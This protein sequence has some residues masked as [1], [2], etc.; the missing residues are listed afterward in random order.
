MAQQDDASFDFAS[1]SLKDLI[2]ARDL[3]HFHLM[4]KANVIGTAVGLYLIRKKEDWPG[5]VGES[6]RPKQK[7]TYART[8]GNSQ[9][10]DYSWP[11]IIVLVREWVDEENFGKDGQPAPWDAVPKRLYLPDGRAVPVCVVMAPPVPLDETTPPVATFRPSAVLGGGLPVEVE[12]QHE[13]HRAT[14][15]CMV[16]DGHTLYALTARHV[17]G[18]SGTEIRAGMRTETPVIGVSSDKQLTRKLFSDVYPA[19]PLRQTWL[20]LDVGLVRIENARDW[21]ANVYG[22]PPIKP[23]FDLYEQNLSLRRLID[24]PVV[25][26]GASSGLLHGRMMALFYRY[27][28]VGGFDYVSDF[29]IAPEEG[30]H[31][32]R[33]GDSGALWQLQMPGP[34]G[35]EDHRPLRQR[36]LRPIAIEWGAQ[37]FVE[38]KAQSTFSVATSLSNICKLLDVELVV[39]HNDG[40]TG[41][42]GAMGHYT[43]G[44]LAI[45]LVQDPELKAFLKANAALL[46]IPLDHLKHAPKNGDLINSGFVPLA[47][48]PDIV[49]K[50]RPPFKDKSGK[51]GGVVGGRDTGSNRGPEH[52]NHHCDADRPWANSQTLPKACIADNSLIN[53]DEWNRYFDAF[54]KPKVA[55][56]HRG[57]LPFRIWQ[58][59][60]RMKGYAH[61][62]PVGFLA[63]A[64]ICAHYVGDASQPL[65]GSILA[66]GYDDDPT[67]KPNVPRNSPKRKGPDKKTKLP[68]YRGEGVHSAFETNMLNSAAGKGVLVPAIRPYLKL[69][70]NPQPAIISN[71]HD[72]ALATLMLMDQVA[73]I[74]PPV[75][76]IDAFED[77]FEAEGSQTQ[78]LWDALDDRT[79]QVI[80][81]GAVTLARLWD[82]AWS[83]G[84]GGENPGEIDPAKLRQCYED[85]DFVKSCYIDDIMN[86][87]E[88]PTPF[89]P[90]DP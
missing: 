9:V 26:R 86:E 10:R 75:D 67:K 16:S 85:P 17:C 54:P 35:K 29:L 52:P 32:A 88:N 21:T 55:D 23:L 7:L 66:D 53:I 39:D 69:P 41:T 74:L 63:A 31:G 81:A 14:I 13:P 44:S 48:I 77:S 36:D 57:I 18:E 90:P 59:F 58:F 38:D 19:L 87:I 11:S 15:G 42:W 72:A 64:G 34:D 4:S 61:A 68:A 30:H 49:W 45:D 1:L 28:T 25:A 27:R 5:A 70:D 12:V 71:G 20:G 76:I 37:T 51:P 82:A 40:V 6:V 24:R 43:I 80:A 78:A 65:H 46:S 2:E 84:N 47:D 8:F 79:G 33:P 56:E 3:Y 22:L 62:H 50:Q 73:T 89:T 60:E 83:F